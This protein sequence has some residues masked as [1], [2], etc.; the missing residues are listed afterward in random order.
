[1]GL[2]HRVEILAKV[3]DSVHVI[4]GLDFV[5]HD[6]IIPYKSAELLVKFH[7]YTFDHF[8]YSKSYQG[9]ICLYNNI[10]N[11]II[12]VIEIHIPYDYKFYFLTK[13]CFS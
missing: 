5:S 8:F 9:K 10:I 2:A 3:T 1:M 12:V 7:H 11:Y 13:L 6:D 4:P